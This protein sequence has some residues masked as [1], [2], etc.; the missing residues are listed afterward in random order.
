MHYQL[1]NVISN[2]WHCWNLLWELIKKSKD[3][4]IRVYNHYKSQSNPILSEYLVN[5][6]TAGVDA[7]G[8][9]SLDSQ[10]KSRK[11]NHWSGQSGSWSWTKVYYLTWIQY[12]SAT[13]PWVHKYTIHDTWPKITPKW[14]FFNAFIFIWP[15]ALTVDGWFCWLPHIFHSLMEISSIKFPLKTQR[16]L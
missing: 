10:K 16:L 8:S 13:K 3:A 15:V 5:A 11:K 9:D 6:D 2:H 14:Q 7:S 12:H 1:C 4:L